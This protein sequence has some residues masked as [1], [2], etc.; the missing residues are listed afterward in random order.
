VVN[1][2]LKKIEY[3]NPNYLERVDY[4]I[5]HKNFFVSVVNFILKIGELLSKC[6]L[7]FNGKSR[8]YEGVSKS[9]QTDRLEQGLQMVQLSDTRCSCIAIL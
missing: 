2:L 6:P 8:D 5:H 9:F 3:I 7:K 1:F 4:N